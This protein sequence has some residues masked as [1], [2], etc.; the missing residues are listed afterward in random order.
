VLCRKRLAG[1]SNYLSRESKMSST[2]LAT[3]GVTRPAE[4]ARLF[5]SMNFGHQRFG[6]LFFPEDYLV[7]L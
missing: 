3:V 1:E 4:R 5:Q 6:G 7:G 2:R